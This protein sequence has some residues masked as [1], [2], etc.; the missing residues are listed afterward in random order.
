[1]E[2]KIVGPSSKMV[3]ERCGVGRG[4]SRYR[5]RGVNGKGIGGN[6]RMSGAGTKNSS[7]ISGING[8]NNPETDD[9]ESR[10]D[11]EEILN[12][13]GNGTNGTG[14]VVASYIYF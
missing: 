8:V 13:V 11:S 9:M 6:G 2:D 4:P 1:M 10:T 3:V 12:T 5:I 14:V 7:S